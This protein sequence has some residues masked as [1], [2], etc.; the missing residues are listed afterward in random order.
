MKVG[1]ILKNLKK[2]KFKKNQ[3]HRKKMFS[4]AEV[5]EIKK[6]YNSGVS[7]RQ[8]AVY[9]G[10]SEKTIRNYLKNQ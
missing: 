10:C 2:S 7:K 9:F 3:G 1:N 6:M 5:I 4:D 8:I